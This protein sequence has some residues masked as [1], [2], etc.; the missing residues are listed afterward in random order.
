MAE[1]KALNLGIIR[2][3][4]RIEVRDAQL[5]CSLSTSPVSHNATHTSYHSTR[6]IAR[7]ATTRQSEPSGE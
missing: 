7:E 1:E 4:H 2:L 5:F 3:R 6:A